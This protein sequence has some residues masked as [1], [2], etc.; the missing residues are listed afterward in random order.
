[1]SHLVV[2][3]LSTFTKLL[4][5][6]LVCVLVTQSCL[7]LCDPMNQ[8]PLPVEFFRQEYWSGLPIP[9]PRD[10]PDPEIKTMSPALSSG[11]LT[12]E[13]PGNSHLQMWRF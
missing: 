6:D 10:L 1:M 2:S 5:V 12:T 8:V 7:T 4:S 11:F 3:I 13:P 9:P